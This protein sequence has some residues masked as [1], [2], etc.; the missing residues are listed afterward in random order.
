MVAYGALLTSKVNTMPERLLA[1]YEGLTA[2]IAAHR[3]AAMA[4][5]ELFFNRNVNTALT[6]GQA[7][8]IALLAAAQAGL[9]VFEYTPLQ[10]KDAVVGYGRAT[11]DQVQQMVAR[12][13]GSRCAEARRR[14]GRPGGGHLPSAQRQDRRPERGSTTMIE[15]IRG[16]V[17][18]CTADGAVLRLGGISIRLGVTGEAV[19]SLQPGQPAELHTHLYMREGLAALYGFASVEERSLFEELM[20]VTGVGPRAA[21]GFLSIFSPTGLREAIA[22]EDLI[23]LTRV[24]GVGRKTA[25]RVI[26]ELKGKLERVGGPSPQPHTRRAIR[27]CSAS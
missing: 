12:C 9:P 26:L 21:L 11:K 14:C 23:R 6:V 25:Q 17:E 15:S 20:G 2:Q 22:N 19:R 24:P 4:V 5:E 1:L 3:P 8:G 18:S 13:S 10:V 7:R 27:N 16:I